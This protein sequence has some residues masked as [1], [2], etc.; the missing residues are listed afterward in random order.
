[1]DDLLQLGAIALKKIALDENA[2]EYILNDKNLYKALRKAADRYVGGETLDETIPKVLKG[3][4]EGFKCSIEFIGESTKTE[5]EANRATQEFLRIIEKIKSEQL[6]SSISLD[7]SHIGLTISPDLC[8]HNLAILCEAAQ[9]DIEVFISAEGVE[10]TDA[11]IDTYKKA[12]KDY[13]NV[14]ITL[15][16]YLYRSKDDFQDLIT[17][18]GRIR[19][20]KGAFHTPEGLS[21]PRGKMLDNI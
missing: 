7:L 18:K 19:I 11:V 5:M 21:M 8:G 6:N 10:R 14:S 3:N 13:S 2:K 4:I 16:A 9:E 12:S 1:M 20:V 17:E 15:Q